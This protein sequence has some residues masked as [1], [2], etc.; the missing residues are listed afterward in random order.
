MPL[1]GNG[2]KKGAAWLWS[3]I[4]MSGPS[5]QQLCVCFLSLRLAPVCLY[6]LVIG[7]SLG[8]CTLREFPSQVPGS[9]GLR[10]LGEEMARGVAYS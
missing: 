4:R 8:S 7:T 6:R 3:M 5:C 1:C 9:L 10:C 2:L